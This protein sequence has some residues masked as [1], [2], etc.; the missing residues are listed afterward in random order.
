MGPFHHGSR[1]QPPKTQ[2]VSHK[3]SNGEVAMKEVAT[4]TGKEK[5][6]KLFGDTFPAVGISV[7]FSTKSK[8][9]FQ[10]TQICCF[11]NLFDTLFSHNVFI[12]GSSM[13]ICTYE[14][15]E[16]QKAEDSAGSERWF[17]RR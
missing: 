15:E 4:P 6:K 12:C 5:D 16:E 10:R 14:S 17:R 1:S 7:L 13:H 9:L 3:Q 8:V 11:A 2:S